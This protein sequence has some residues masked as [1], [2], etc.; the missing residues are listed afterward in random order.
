M[1]PCLHS[2]TL[3]SL[4]TSWPAWGNQLRH[5]SA[6]WQGHGAQPL[7]Q[8]LSMLASS[9]TTAC[10]CPVRTVKYDCVIQQ[11]AAAMSTEVTGA[12]LH[13]E[14]ELAILAPLVV[15]TAKEESQLCT[16]L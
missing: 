12:D 8:F 9:H 6:G 5:G 11:A 14:D 16:Q 1:W 13:V 2:E 10:F 3:T 4:L 7:L 15:P